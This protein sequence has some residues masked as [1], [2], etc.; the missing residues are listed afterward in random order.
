MQ[1]YFQSIF[2]EMGDMKVFEFDPY[3]AKQG[4]MDDGSS[5]D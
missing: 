1:N 3:S 2:C 5:H 4:K